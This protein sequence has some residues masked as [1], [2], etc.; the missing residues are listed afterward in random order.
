VL[1]VLDGDLLWTGE[2]DPDVLVTQPH[3][4][5]SSLPADDED[6]ADRPA[7]IPAHDVSP[8]HPNDGSLDRNERGPSGGQT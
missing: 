6:S 3:K 1:D 8:Q 2:S 4:L 7:A 5:K